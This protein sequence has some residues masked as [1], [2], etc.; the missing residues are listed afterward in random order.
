MS[1]HTQH[2]MAIR[3]SFFV[4]YMQIYPFIYRC[5]ISMH[6]CKF[7]C[8]S[9]YPTLRHTHTVAPYYPLQFNPML[10]FSV[11]CCSL[12]CCCRLFFVPVL[13]CVIH[14]VVYLRTYFILTFTRLKN[15][16]STVAWTPLPCVRHW[17]EDDGPLCE[18]AHGT[19]STC[20]HIKQWRRSHLYSSLW[21]YLSCSSSEAA[22]LGK[23]FLHFFSSFPASS[24]PPSHS[25]AP[26]MAFKTIIDIL[27]QDQCWPGGEQGDV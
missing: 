14:W 26:Q 18:A 5:T 15:D 21:P 19:Q 17:F 8:V 24:A 22:T 4:I 23:H 13:L 2:Y 1:L 6:L 12:C 11:C 3:L 25:L 7:K 10:F 27:R 16:P 20:S 9:Y